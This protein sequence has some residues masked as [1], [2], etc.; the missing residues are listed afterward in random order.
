MDLQSSSAQCKQ[1][2][3]S[4]SSSS[5]KRAV[6]PCFGLHYSTGQ[7][8]SLLAD[9]GE[10]FSASWRWSADFMT[11]GSLGL[12]T[13]SSLLQLM[14]EPISDERSPGFSGVACSGAVESGRF[15]MYNMLPRRLD[16]CRRRRARGKEHVDVN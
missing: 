11:S 9:G 2:H 3:H 13:I 8:V 6:V 1:I 14:G 7:A 15:I 4:G 16:T 12:A 5:P 10:L